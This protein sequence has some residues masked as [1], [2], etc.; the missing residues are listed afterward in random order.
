VVS[1]VQRR[2]LNS[3][4]RVTGGKPKGIVLLRMRSSVVNS[5]FVRAEEGAQQLLEGN[6]GKG[7]RHHTFS[8]VIICCKR[9]SRSC[10]GKCSTAHCLLVTGGKPEGIVLSLVKPKVHTTLLPAGLLAGSGGVACVEEHAPEIWVLVK[11]GWRASYSLGGHHLLQT[12][13]SLV[14]R[15][16]P[17]S[18]L[19]VGNWGK[20]RRASYSLGGHHLLQTLVSLVWR[21]VPA[22]FLIVGNWGKSRRASYSLGGHHLLQTLVSLVQ[23]KVPDSSLLVTG[24]SS[25]A[26]TGGNLEGIVLPR[27]SSSVANVGLARAEESARQ[28]IACW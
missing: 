16:V 22:S 13:V 4:L 26:G 15:K 14:W 25:L 8:G 28:L 24:I 27:V 9:W 20:S 7:G 1:F 19:I 11:R 2:V 23:R 5:G 10:R 12:L 17:A 3:F 21:K 6:W 18:F